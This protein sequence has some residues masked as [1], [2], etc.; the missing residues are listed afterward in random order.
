MMGGPSEKEPDDIPMDDKQEEEPSAETKE[1]PP[2]EGDDKMPDADLKKGFKKALKDNS[3]TIAAFSKWAEE[4][5]FGA[6]DE[7]THDVMATFIESMPNI[8]DQLTKKK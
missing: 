2:E 7:W 8:A 5:K 6:A 4:S 3:V 1:P